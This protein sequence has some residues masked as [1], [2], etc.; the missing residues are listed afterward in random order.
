MPTSINNLIGLFYEAFSGKPG[1]LDT[2]F[3]GDWDDIALG[4]GQE[5]GH[6]GLRAPSEG[7]S[8]AFIN[9]RVVV[10][11]I[12]DAHGGEDGNAMVDVRATMHGVHTGEFFGIAPTGGHTAPFR[13]RSSCH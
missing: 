5:P 9:F 13:V 11:E 1:L 2:V 3:T 12:I 4:P 8:N 7:L 10:E 6:A